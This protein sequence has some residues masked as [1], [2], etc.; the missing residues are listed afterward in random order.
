M[1]SLKMNIR[2]LAASA[3]LAGVIAVSAA[4][5]GLAQDSATSSVTIGG[6]NFTASISASNFAS[7]PYSLTDQT[8]RGGIL[9]VT[10]SDQT[11]DAAGW[12]ITVTLSDFIGQTRPNEAIPSENLEITSFAITV[13][14]DGSQPVSEPNMPVVYG[15]TLPQLTW[16]ALSG[17][18]Q[19][20]YNLNMVGDLL[21]PGRTTAQTYTS[22][23]TLQIVSG[24]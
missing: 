3:C 4:L 5:P 2:K 12:Q 23:G 1:G 22:T 16:S 24:P 21:V 9:S 7:L 6:G 17:Y 11:G 18:G 14:A 19:G 15:E 13:A 10:V 8:A 20:A